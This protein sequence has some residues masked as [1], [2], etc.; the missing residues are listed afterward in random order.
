[1]AS[2]SPCPPSE[3]TRLLHQLSDSRRNLLQTRGLL[4]LTIPRPL[5][6]AEA[7]MRWYTEPPDVARTDRRW[8]TDGSLKYGRAADCCRTG[9][10]IVVVYVSGELAALGNAVPPAWVRTS[11]AAELWAVWLVFS[12]CRGIPDIVTDCL[13]I[14]KAAEMGTASVTGPHRQLASI[15]ASIAR[16]AGIDVSAITSSHRLVWMPAHKSLA[17]ARTHVKSDSR[18]VTIVDWRANRLADVLA[19]SAAEAPARC[20]A[21]YRLLQNAEILVKHEAA[22]VGVVTHAANHHEVCTVSVDGKPMTRLLRDSTGQRRYRASGGHVD[23]APAPAVVVAAP[24]SVCAPSPDV[25]NALHAL[26]CPPARHERQLHLAFARRSAS[27]AR[28]ASQMEHFAGLCDRRGAR[29]RPSSE[30]PAAERIAGVLSRVR[31]REGEARPVP[32]VAVASAGLTG[33]S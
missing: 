30:P 5:P 16:A 31:R 6:Q 17:A 9:C 20:K 18:P 2:E 1:M 24:A 15:W 32:S 26:C 19:K 29:L 11:A 7:P 4:V 33:N 8:F 14:V 27:A 23:A 25:T 3:I 28:K 12:I 13:S 10:S 22:L 21:G